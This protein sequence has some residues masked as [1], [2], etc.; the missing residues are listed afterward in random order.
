MDDEDLS[1]PVGGV[2]VLFYIHV[3]VCCCGRCLVSAVGRRQCW[4]PVELGSV[5]LGG[6]GEGRHWGRRDPPEETITTP[7]AMGN[8]H[9]VGPHR[10]RKNVHWR[11]A[12]EDTERGRRRERPPPPLQSLTTRNPTIPIFRSSNTGRLPAT[13]VNT[14]DRPRGA[15]HSLILAIAIPN[16]EVK[17]PLSAHL[18]CFFSI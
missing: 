12:G 9:S 8:T 5:G 17:R 11:A 13:R 18:A 4:P 1:R 16:R 2:S 14:P 15:R 6:G 10:T 3:S 7:L